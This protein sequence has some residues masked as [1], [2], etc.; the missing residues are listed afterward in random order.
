MQ[1][2]PYGCIRHCRTGDY[3]KNDTCDDAG[4]HVLVIM[5]FALAGAVKRVDAEGKAVKKQDCYSLV[6]FW[7]YWNYLSE[8]SFAIFDRWRQ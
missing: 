5:S 4:P 1:W 3:Y 7:F 2:T 6:C 8:L